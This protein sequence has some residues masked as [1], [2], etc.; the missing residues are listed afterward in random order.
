M[1]GNTPQHKL[2]SSSHSNV[3]LRAVSS[4][5]DTR[6]VG[7]YYSSGSVTYAPVQ[8]R[9][10]V[11]HR[12]WA[13][14]SGLTSYFNGLFISTPGCVCVCEWGRFFEASHPIIWGPQV[15]KQHYNSF[16]CVTV[17]DYTMTVPHLM[18]LR[19]Q[20]NIYLWWWW[21]ATGSMWHLF[22]PCGDCRF[23]GYEYCKRKNCVF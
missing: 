8:L 21:R 7:E 5:V 13:T 14:N 18:Q 2:L 16:C 4:P 23:Q 17:L 22:F 15:G 9:V 1:D 6:T 12:P 10:T 19:S 11:T 20:S 3:S